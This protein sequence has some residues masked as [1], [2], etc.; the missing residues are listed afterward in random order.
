[1]PVCKKCN[2]ETEKTCIHCSSPV[3]EEHL[4]QCGMT[5]YAGEYCAQK[6]GTMV[7]YTCSGIICIDCIKEK[8][9]KLD[10]KYEKRLSNFLIQ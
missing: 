9:V 5:E 1:M 6:V 2:A 10:P 4:I 7:V 8:N 3:C